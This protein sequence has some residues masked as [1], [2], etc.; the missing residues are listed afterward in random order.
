M[1][2]LVDACPL[3]N[4]SNFQYF[5]FIIPSTIL[6]CIGNLRVICSCFLMSFDVLIWSF[7]HNVPQLIMALIRFSN[8]WIKAHQSITISD[9]FGLP[10]AIGKRIKCVNFSCLKLVTF[11]HISLSLDSRIVVL[12]TMPVEFSCGR[13]NHLQYKGS[14]LRSLNVKCP[15][16]LISDTM[17]KATKSCVDYSTVHFPK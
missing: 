16:C 12:R 6:F 13:H 14:T 7:C 11:F 10:M 15:T 4:D 2:L 1:R 3:M 17:R 9:T 8:V 5:P